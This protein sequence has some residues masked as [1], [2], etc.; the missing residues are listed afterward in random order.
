MYTKIHGKYHKNE[1]YNPMNFYQVKEIFN[2]ISFQ[3]ISI[4]GS[5]FPF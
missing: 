4:T 3:I 2:F 1:P 5:L